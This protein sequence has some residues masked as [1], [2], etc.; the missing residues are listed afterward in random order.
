MHKHLC[1]ALVASMSGLIGGHTDWSSGSVAP[2][3]TVS[4][5][6]FQALTSPGYGTVAWEELG[7]VAP[8]RL[9]DLKA[10]LGLLQGRGIALVL[11]W[12]S[13]DLDNPER[14]AVVADA[15]SRGIPV[16]PWLTLPEGSAEDNL[17]SSPNYPKTGYFPNSTNYV[18]WIAKAKQLMSLWTARGLPPT[19]MSVDLEMRKRRLHQFAEMTQ[20]GAPVSQ[21][22]S[23]LREEINRPRH[24][25]ALLAFRD[26]V[27]YA[28]SRGFKVN[29]TTLLP[30]LDDYGD[31]DDSLRQAFGIPL[32]DDPRAANATP[33][34]EVSFQVH[35]TIYQQSYPGLTSYFVLDYARL[36]IVL[37]GAK[38]GVGIGLTHGGIAPETPVYPNGNEL[39]LDVEAARKAGIP[40]AK[41]GVYSFLGMYTAPPTSQWFQAPQFSFGPFPDLATGAVHVST[42]AL[43]GLF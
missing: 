23:F 27:S 16:Y 21:I 25:A 33:W 22:V 35:R 4:T 5:S 37:F 20:N 42:W 9:Q 32:D 10:Q 36:A 38:A 39:R 11:H 31:D 28:H 40:T 7:N 43:D 13:N 18:E 15:R 3:D 14:W 12:P 8:Y 17:P 6:K 2:K 26:Y 34:D 30:M 1:I 24:A 19:T 29:V 41:I